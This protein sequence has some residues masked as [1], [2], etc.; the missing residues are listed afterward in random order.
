[1]IETERIE[2]EEFD[3]SDPSMRLIEYALA[4]VA[5]AVAA[6]LAFLR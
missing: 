6:I 5:V 3:Q 2:V 4:F 1:M